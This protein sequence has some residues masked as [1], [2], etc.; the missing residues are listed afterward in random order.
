MSR[1]NAHKLNGH[2]LTVSLYYPCLQLDEDFMV[3]IPPA[4]QLD[5]LDDYI[6]KYVNVHV[7]LL[8]TLLYVPTTFCFIFCSCGSMFDISFRNN[9]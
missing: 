7:L 3:K 6:L 5:E 2:E 1:N 9:T 4:I 8:V